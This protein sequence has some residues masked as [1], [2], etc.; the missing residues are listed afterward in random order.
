MYITF[1][2]VGTIGAIAGMF[3]LIAALI[4]THNL[5]TY[6]AGIDNR[7]FRVGL[8]GAINSLDPALMTEPEEQFVASALYEGL[9]YLDEKSGD[10][11]P[12]LAKSWKYSKD[13]KTLT[14]KLKDKV[15]FHNNQNLTAQKVKEAWEKNLINCR[16]L[17]RINLYMAVTGA[18]EYLNG[19]QNTITGIQAVD[20]TTLKITF[21]NPDS[22][23]PYKLCNPAFWVYDAG[24]ETADPQPGT[25]PFTLTGNKDNQEFLLISNISYHRGAPHLA[26]IDIAV[27]SDENTAFQNYK[28][29][30]LDY[31][32]KVP[33]AEVRNIRQDTQLNS[34]L[35]EKPLLE[36]YALGMNVNKEP[37]AGNYMLRRAFNYAVDRNQI[38]GDIFAESYQ[39]VKGVI[40]AQL[41][42]FN[43]EMPG[44]AFNPEK[45]RQLLA[46][47][48]CP[49]GEGL[50]TI[51][52]SYNRGEGHQ[53]V[54]EA[55]VQQLS[56]LGISIQLQP[57]EW[58]YYKKQMQQSALTFFRIG[59]AADYPDADSFLYGLFHS[60]MAG[61][62]NY[63]GYHNPQVDKLLDAARA[64]IKS[65]EER[66]KLLKRA[67]EIIVDDAP[68]LWLLQ[69][70]S[71]AI[72]GPQTRG[73]T[74]NSLG[75]ID[76]R[77]IELK[78][79]EISGESP[80]I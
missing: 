68:F 42:G 41:N 45:A 63:T 58:E 44:Y 80:S 2:K 46:E 7:P 43:Q 51:T 21:I 10:I 33:L 62:G 5:A 12:L 73:L 3:I 35:L 19:S 61:R 27:F 65:N 60:S 25:G 40:P 17:G 66:L 54:A 69:R 14:V 34:F 70:K 24:A 78:K 29:N 4:Y 36:I 39:P 55:I 77:L 79:P 47:M 37:F 38:A 26:G 59:W 15:K 72:T 28:E 56:P 76:W 57:M 30:K 50:K 67:E 53:M 49:E 11:K 23:F 32:D 22:A 31:L 1:R 6:T 48:E 8:V 18:D 75:M 13:G 74:I 71:A 20:G 64:E 9:V 16:E 52:F